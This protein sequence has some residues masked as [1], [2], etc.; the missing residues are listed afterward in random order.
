VAAAGRLG[1]DGAMSQQAGEPNEVEPDHEV[2]VVQQFACTGART[3]VVSE[4]FSAVGVV[5]EVMEAPGRGIELLMPLEAAEGLLLV[6][7]LGIEKARL[8]G[9]SGFDELSE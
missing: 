3:L 6:L 9:Q 5:L 7:Q 4:D 8:A 1:D 2:K